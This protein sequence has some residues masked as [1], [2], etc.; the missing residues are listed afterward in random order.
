MCCTILDGDLNARG[1]ESEVASMEP[2]EFT[3]IE[4][5]RLR[6]R[7]FA[8]ADLPAFIAY[9]NDPLIAQYQSWEGITEAEA[10]AFVREQEAAPAGEAG[11]WLQIAVERKDDG[12]MIGDC[13][14]KIMADDSRQA[15][16]GYTLARDAQRQGFATEAVAALLSWVF[17][18]FDLHR[19]VAIVDARNTSS[20][21]L[22]ERLGLRR[23]AHFR[24][25]VWF[26]GAWGDDYLYA[27]LRDE[28]PP[29]HAASPD[30]R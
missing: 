24:Q 16:I 1:E 18:T 23:E 12:R 7:R 19:V 2:T 11:K 20:A 10:V 13:A 26:K 3:T 27:I 28:W 29:T 6:L 15:E 8:D 21:A 9:R 4:T 5:A 22:L 14:F 17:P 30:E 25:N